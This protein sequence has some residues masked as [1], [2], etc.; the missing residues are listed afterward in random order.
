MSSYCRSIPGTI[1]V[2]AVAAG[3]LSIAVST[4]QTGIARHALSAA[5]KKS[6]TEWK[7]YAG[8][9][10]NIKYS[11]LDQITPD[12]IKTL[13]VAWTYSSGEASMLMTGSFGRRAQAARS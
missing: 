3:T 2:A 4:A 9:N 7:V 8:G 1:A 13:Q 6:Y 11:A 10:E 5:R 12:N